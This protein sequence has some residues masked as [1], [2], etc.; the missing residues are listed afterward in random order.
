[1]AQ[2]LIVILSIVLTAV[3]IFASLNYMPAWMNQANDTYAVVKAGFSTLETAYAAAAKANGGVAP[4]PNTGATDG[5]LSASFSAFYGYLPKAPR[6]Y[7]W[8]Y[9]RNNNVNADYFCLYSPT[10]SAQATEGVWRGLNRVRNVFSDEQYFIVAGGVGACD[11]ALPAT[12]QSA[13]A[14][15]PPGSYPALLSV[16]YLVKY[17]PGP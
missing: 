7:T 3:T 9:G 2:L 4:A 6:G 11:A 16:V 12:P 15:A 5:G 13:A 14:K 1:M 8:K 10:G 17:L